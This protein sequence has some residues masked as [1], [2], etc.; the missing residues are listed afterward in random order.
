[1]IR[2]VTFD[3][4]QTLADDVPDNLAA[5]RRLRLDALDAAVRAV[6]LDPDPVRV[7]AGYERSQGL[8]EERFWNLHRDPGFAEQVALVLD[9][10]EPGASARVRGACLETLL[11]GYADPVLHRPPCLCPGAAEAVRAL[12]ARGVRLGVI[13]NTGRTP[14]TALR[15]YL[16]HQGLLSFFRV[17]TFSDEV[18]IR[19]P[20][21]E[22][23]RRTLAKLGPE[24]GLEPGEVA[25]IGDNPHADVEGARA[26]GMRAVHYAVGGQAGAARADL[27]TTDLAALPE[28][29]AAL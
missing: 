3:F 28:R 1:V 2:A 5:Q 20:D 23:F 27:V 10:L 4:W 21:G 19:K 8:L 9:C 15:R 25:H 13:S 6:G 7:E 26:V 22:I 11:R 18:G 12:A 16:E 29:L 14:G 24:L 17:V